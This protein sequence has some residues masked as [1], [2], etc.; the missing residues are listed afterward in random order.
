M[1]INILCV[2]VIYL[3]HNVKIQDVM[4]T[5]NLEDLS[6][7]TSSMYNEKPKHYSLSTT[8]KYLKHLIENPVQFYQLDED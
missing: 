8:K 7:R 2:N 5:N 6:N 4:P 1:Y 3:D